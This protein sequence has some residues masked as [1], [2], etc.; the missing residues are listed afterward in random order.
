MLPPLP[1]LLLKVEK[2]CLRIVCMPVDNNTFCLIC[3][4]SVILVKVEV[5]SKQQK[6]NG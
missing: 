3:S 4:L 2:K 1:R 5:I 6:Q